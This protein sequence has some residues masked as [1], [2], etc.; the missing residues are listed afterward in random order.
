MIIN[1]LQMQTAGV[2]T[3]KNK[4]FVLDFFLIEVQCQN[5]SPCV[6]DCKLFDTNQ[7]I[8]T[9]VKGVHGF[10]GGGTRKEC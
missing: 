1:K 7:L 4:V 5:K 8:L 3:F 10:F 9:V 2:P 6:G